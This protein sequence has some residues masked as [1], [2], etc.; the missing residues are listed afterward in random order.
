MFWSGVSRFS[1]LNKEKTVYRLRAVPW[2]SKWRRGVTAVCSRDS[3]ENTSPTKFFFTWRW[4]SDSVVYGRRGSSFRSDTRIEWVDDKTVRSGTPLIKKKKKQFFSFFYTLKRKKIIIR[5]M[6]FK[7]KCKLSR[8]V[9]RGMDWETTS[10]SRFCF[11][12]TKG[13]NLTLVKF[14]KRK[15]NSRCF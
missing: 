1:I 8:I 12:L 2:S 6:F 9:L 5:T 4:I 13:Y 3:F 7:P 15:R 11:M 10:S 14:L